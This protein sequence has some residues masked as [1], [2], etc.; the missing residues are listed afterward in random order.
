MSS[1]NSTLNQ[2]VLDILLGA[3]W[4]VADLV[5]PALSLMLP[6]TLPCGSGRSVHHPRCGMD[7]YFQVEVFGLPVTNGCI[8]GRDKLRI[9]PPGM[10]PTGTVNKDRAITILKL[11]H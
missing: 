1:A 8:L 2:S 9:Y 4:H 6:T 11:L 3:W 7:Y 5:E 10:Y